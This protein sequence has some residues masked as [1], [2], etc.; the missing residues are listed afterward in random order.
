MTM[1]SRPALAT[2][3]AIALVLGAGCSTTTTGSSSGS[4]AGAGAGST[5][6]GA[7]AAP[8]TRASAPKDLQLKTGADVALPAAADRCEIFTDECLLPFPSNAFTEP[9]ATTATKVRVDLA[10]ESMPA[11]LA[12][13]HIDPTEWNRQDGFSPGSMIV[14]KVDG[15][16]LAATGAAPVNDIGRS[17]DA[18]APIVLLDADTGQRVPY[19]AELDAQEHLDLAK[20]GADRR[21]LIIRPARNFA[22]GHR[23]V[24]ALRNLKTAGGTTIPASPTFAAVRDRVKTTHPEIEERRADLEDALA[25][26]EAAGV[27]RDD[28][29]L[30]WPFTVASTKN[31]TERVLFM[32]DDAFKALG[33]E[34]PAFT[35]TSTTESTDPGIARVVV[36]T[37]D[38]PNY[39]TNNGDPGSTLDNAADPNGIP[40][41]TGRYKA[42]FLCVVPTSSYTQPAHAVVYG[43]GLLGSVDEVKSVGRAIGGSNNLVVCGTDEIGMSTRDIGPVAQTLGDLSGFR[44]LPDRTQQAFVNELF[45]GRALKHAK[46]FRSDKAFQTPAGTTGIGDDLYYVGNSQGG[47]MG[48]AVTAIAQDW[49]RAFLGVPAMNYATLLNRSVDFDKYAVLLRA[50]YPDP[51]TQQIG[52]SLIQMLWDRGENNGYANHLTSDPLPGTPAKQVLI[53]AAFGDHQVTNVA[54]DVLAR[55]IGS[56]VQTPALAAGR[57]TDKTPFWGIEPLTTFP[58]KANAYVMWDFGTPAPPLSNTPNRAG[59]D[60]HGKGRSSPQVQKLVTTFL[61]TGEVVDVCDAKP[62]QTAP[63]AK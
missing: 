8:F 41:R 38:V 51:L 50:Q 36:G 28:L 1:R 47:I 43:H 4:P 19:Y 40:K 26:L 17:L 31:L 25:Q 7:T 24:A 15:L 32:R 34:A 10:K 21:A 45:L 2:A 58:A 12:G 20:A 60:P 16:D 29:Y 61:F 14:T 48:G 6:P 13:V 49:T 37:F 42:N 9:D 57:S 63:A 23:I 27:K 30:A 11:N 52:F 5:T 18:D 3:L 54:T 35:V 33:D 62:C 59:D 55:T 46:G 53:F 22:D 56:K 44:S 39:L